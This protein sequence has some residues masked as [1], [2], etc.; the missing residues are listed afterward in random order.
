MLSTEPDLG[1]NKMNKTWLL[2]LKSSQSSLRREKGKNAPGLSSLS[3]VNHM[4]E[5]VLLREQ[6]VR[7][8]QVM[9]EH[10]YAL[11][12]TSPAIGSSHLWRQA[13]LKIG[14]GW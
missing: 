4:P 10:S 11:T 1:D 14:G 9:D 8:Q 2:S 13:A 5:P 12:G 7:F 3:R 6:W